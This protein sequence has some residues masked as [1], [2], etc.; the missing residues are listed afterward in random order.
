MT[1]H[2]YFNLA[3]HNSTDEGI[4]NHILQIHANSYTELDSENIP[5]RKV[6]DL[7]DDPAMDF[8][9]GKYLI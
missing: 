2:S 8:R 5:T 9:K 4:M 3:G 1:N 7:K 6:I